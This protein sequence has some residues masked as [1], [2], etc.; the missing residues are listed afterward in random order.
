MSVVVTGGIT[1]HL[2]TYAL[3]MVLGLYL[4]YFTP[5]GVA[6]TSKLVEDLYLYLFFFI[7]IQIPKLSLG[8]FFLLIWITFLICLLASWWGPYES[9]STVVSRGSSRPVRA[10]LNNALFILPVLSSMLLL[11][12]EAVSRFQESQGIPTGGLNIPDP[13]YLFFIASASAVFEEIGYRLIPLGL[14]VVIYTLLSGYEQVRCLPPYRWLE[15]VL[16]G[17]IYPEGAKGRVGLRTVRASGWVKG[18]SKVEW[19]AVLITALAFGLAHIF[20]ASGW[21]LGKFASA[22]LAGALFALVYLVYGLAAAILMH[23]FF[24]YY[25]TA[26]SLA[27]TLSI[28]GFETLVTILDFSFFWF[29]YF[30]WFAL[31]V[32]LLGKIFGWMKQRRAQQT[33]SPIPAEGALL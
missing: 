7:P 25:L 3:A 8:V 29:G 22:S 33:A 32:I 6:L 26:L 24:N 28:P 20:S 11:A 13:F 21:G 19:S 14:V 1:F 31:G 9:V 18:L 10:L 4:F 16:L 12:E 27:Y 30:G 5:Q 17:F 15:I 23:W 2:A